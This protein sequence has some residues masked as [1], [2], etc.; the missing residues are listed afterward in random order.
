M[1]YYKDYGAHISLPT[2][3]IIVLGLLEKED[4][5]EQLC[6]GGTSKK[7]THFGQE[8]IEHAREHATPILPNKTA[9]SKHGGH[10]Y[11]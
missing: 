7:W 10:Y 1:H 2:S 4:D 8:L 6:V 5:D 3:A 11:L 9:K